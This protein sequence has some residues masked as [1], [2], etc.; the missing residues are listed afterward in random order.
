MASNTG[1]QIN[2][3]KTL[4]LATI[5]LCSCTSNPALNDALWGVAKSGAKYEFQHRLQIKTDEIIHKGVDVGSVEACERASNIIH[6]GTQ[7]RNLFGDEP[8]QAIKLESHIT[9]FMIDRNVSIKTQGLILTTGAAALKIAQSIAK[10]EGDEL[11]I[12]GDFLRSVLF[13]AEDA[14][15]YCGE[16]LAVVEAV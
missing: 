2:M 13:A 1:N 10:N 16:D 3:K 11:I 8:V 15:K 12:L 5:L 6:F 9:D 4:I 7:A 14:K